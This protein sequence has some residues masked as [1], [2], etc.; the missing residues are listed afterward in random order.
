MPRRNKLEIYIAV[1]KVL[2]KNGPMKTTHISQNVNVNPSV[3]NEYLDFFQKQ[4]LVEQERI[5]KR[6]M[7]K[8]TQ[9][10]LKVL[11]YFTEIRGVLQSVEKGQTIPTITYRLR[12][13]GGGDD[14]EL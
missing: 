10:G 6:V 2:A 14:E 9:R 12:K 7:Y 4:K 8:L 1:L 5:G 11:E 13:K 3:L